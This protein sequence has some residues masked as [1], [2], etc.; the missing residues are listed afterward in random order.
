MLTQ[1]ENQQLLQTEMNLLRDE[2]IEVYNASGKR[3]TGEF[4]QGLTIEFGTNKAILK[5]YEYLGG[6]RPNAGKMPPIQKIEDWLNAKGIK[7]IEDKMKIS[8]LAY[9]IARKISKEGTKKENN[10]AIYSKVIT[11]QRIDQILEKIQTLNANAFIREVTALI[12]T[13]FNENH[14]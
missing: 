10:L 11:P 1:D 7:P 2:I 6:R 14:Q 3:T 5:G 4:E 9:L 13:S 12:T 8:T